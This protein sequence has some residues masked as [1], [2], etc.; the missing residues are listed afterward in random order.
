MSNG[1]CDNGGIGRN[2]GCVLLIWDVDLFMSKC[3][4]NFFSHFL[5]PNSFKILQVNKIQNVIF[6]Q[7]GRV[8]VP[9]VGQLR[10]F[11]RVTG[12]I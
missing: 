7:L 3:F 2:F 4:F 1:D 8:I 6:L 11:S 10:L 12:N 5:P 9:V